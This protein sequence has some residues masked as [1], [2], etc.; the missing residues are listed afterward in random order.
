MRVYITQH[1]GHT[2]YW[3]S[4]GVVLEHLEELLPEC[5]EGA[6]V[7][8]SVGEVAKK[9]LEDLPEFEGY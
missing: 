6:E 4:L 1:E 3:E 8:V 7:L 5:E 2:L 9:D